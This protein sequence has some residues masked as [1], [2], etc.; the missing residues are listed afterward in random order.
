MTA[1][2]ARIGRGSLTW[3]AG[4]LL[5]SSAAAAPFAWTNIGPDAGSVESLGYDQ[6]NNLVYAGATVGGLWISSDGGQTWASGNPAS[7]G[8]A[9]QTTIHTMIVLAGSPGTLVVGTDDG[10]WNTNL[11]ASTSSSWVRT[12]AGFP[13]NTKVNQI[14]FA[15]ANLVA[16]TATQ[17]VQ[18]ILSGTWTAENGGLG[19]AG[20][21]NVHAF[22]S[23]TGGA[24]QIVIGTAAGVYVSSSTTPWTWVQ[25]NGGLPASPD[26]RT[27]AGAGATG[28]EFLWG[29][30]A[31]GHGV[32]VSS[33]PVTGLLS[34]CQW[35]NGVLAS[36]GGDVNSL[37]GDQ[38][39]L[40]ALTTGGVFRTPYT[41]LPVCTAVPN[42]VV[43]NSGLVVGARDVTAALIFPTPTGTPT[44]GAP[45]VAML[46]GNFGDGV[47]RAANA[48]IP[49]PFAWSESDTN[50]RAGLVFDVRVNGTPSPA[51]VYG[52]LYGGVFRSADAG[53]SWTRRNTGLTVSGNDFTL[54]H[55]V[56]ILPSPSDSG[57]TSTTLVAGADFFTYLFRSTSSAATWSQAGVSIPIGGGSIGR[58]LFDP[59]N[60]NNVY[61][62]LVGNGSAVRG[63]VYKSTDGGVTWASASTGLPTIGAG[64]Q[65]QEVG[66]QAV[67]T[68]V[69][70]AGLN[71][72]GA[73]AN[74]W[75]WRSTDGGGS[76]TQVA[77]V[78]PVTGGNYGVASLDVDPNNVWVGLE[79]GALLQTGSGGTSWY[80]ASASLAA[81]AGGTPIAGRPISAVHINP[82]NSSHVWASV[83]GAGVFESK[84]GGATWASLDP[85]HVPN[86][87]VDSLR[88]DYATNRLYAGVVGN[89]ILAYDLASRTP[90]VTAT[91]TVSATVTATATV[92]ATASASAS[93]TAT[94]TASVTTTA[95]NSS[96]PTGTSTA[97][98][99][100]TFTVTA[101]ATMTP[102][103]TATPIGSGVVQPFP[104]PF[105]VAGGVPLRFA[106]QLPADQTVTITIYDGFENL[107]RGMTISAGSP[108]AAAGN[109]VQAPWDGKNDRGVF[110]TTGVYVAVVEAGGARL[111][112]PVK[113]VVVNP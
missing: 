44:P 76:W 46:I 96:T 78:P 36:F 94:G 15:G 40:F 38:N 70:Y 57:G 82:T 31:N 73:S 71:A 18:V 54:V 2:V 105:H 17:G 49:T 88:Y 111:G 22:T 58:I 86:K 112:N 29:G 41:V 12:G 24:G 93:S 10:V 75:V 60:S 109:N 68:P 84:D 87:G 64:P 3:A 113:I 83:S 52:G 74:D 62:A 59:I 42:W 27:A 81:A 26:V 99:S 80:D 103:S 104:N 67:S 28:Q 89:S 69:V 101:S 100:I 30:L 90:T 102:T 97:T 63:G 13:A 48:P 4:F 95:S 56:G 50:L 108:G 9:A 25:Q 53:A 33:W 98:A 110:V 77:S 5:A 85:T 72:G 34:W 8:V 106:Y 107:V 51:Q 79:G 7:G 47:W 43:E 21:M 35:N 32:Y 19:A 92:S 61:L 1:L 6:A 16:C 11:P 66:V 20:S 65:V 37:V 45:P 39:Y 23:R 14:T 55:S 91:A